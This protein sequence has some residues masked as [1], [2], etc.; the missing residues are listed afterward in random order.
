[1]GTRF[2]AVDLGKFYF[3]QGHYHFEKS[4]YSDAT[5]SLRISYQIDPTLF[6]QIDQLLI[7]QATKLTKQDRLTKTYEILMD[8]L[9]ISPLF[10]Q[11]TTKLDSFT[12]S[13]AIKRVKEEK[14]RF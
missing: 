9:S 8:A 10:P 5:N 3:N 2:L 1:M 6:T 12:L 14:G 4:N 11:V 13:A 7:T